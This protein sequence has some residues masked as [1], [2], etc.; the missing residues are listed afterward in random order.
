MIDAPINRY[1]FDTVM[2]MRLA[3]KEWQK[4]LNDRPRDAG[5]PFAPDATIYFINASLS[6]VP[7]ADERL[8]L[9][10]I[11]TTLY[12]EDHDVDRLVH[13]ASNLVLNDVDFKRLMRDIEADEATT[14]PQTSHSL[15]TK[16]CAEFLM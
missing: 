10:R 13:A 9:M 8:S 4:E 6:D 16:E 3:L 5:S 2:L 1:S 7:D 12:L 11:P 15:K 14:I